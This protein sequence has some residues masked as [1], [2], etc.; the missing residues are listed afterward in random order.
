MST[1]DALWFWQANLGR[2]VGK[3][4]FVRNFL[5]VYRQARSAVI[6]LQEVDEADK[7]EEADIIR[8]IAQGTH[9]LVGMRTGVPILV[10]RDL[11]LIGWDTRLACKGLA[12]YTPNRYVTEAVVDLRNG[13][14]VG[15]F[16]THVPLLR[17]ATLTRRRDVR[18]ALREET[19]GH[20]N[21]L[22]VA[23]TNTR[24]GW[25]TIVKGEKSAV[26]AEIDKA[27]VWAKGSGNVIVTHRRSVD[28]TIDNHNAHGARSK[29]INAA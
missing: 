14:Q 13:T 4:E 8:D 20:R 2:G 25:P 11:D 7:P 1:T 17:V 29:W 19:R 27:K 5:R 23:D 15:M 22:W 26:D 18:Q 3:D 16:N 24:R 12:K 28:L 9:R 6:L 10:P 21:G